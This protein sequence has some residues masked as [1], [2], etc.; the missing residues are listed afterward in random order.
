RDR[1]AT[2]AIVEQDDALAGFRCAAEDVTDLEADAVARARRFG[3]EDV[4]SRQPVEIAFVHLAL[5][6]PRFPGLDVVGEQV[7]RQHLVAGALEA[8]ADRAARGDAAAVAADRAG[9]IDL[10][11]TAARPGQLTGAMNRQSP[12]IESNRM[13]EP[14]PGS[15]GRRRMR[16]RSRRSV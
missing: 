15:S 4:A 8:F 14:M 2:L 6:Q 7:R 1:A 12:R 9:E 10:H 5:G 3:D 13:S 11:E 16:L